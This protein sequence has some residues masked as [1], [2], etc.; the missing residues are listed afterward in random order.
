VSEPPSSSEAPSSWA[1]SPEL[2]ARVLARLGETGQP[3]ER[4]V[5]LFNVGNERYLTVL[6][7][8]Y[9]VPIAEHRRG[10]SFKLV[11]AYY[12]G[13][14]THFLLCLR[15]RAWRRGLAAAVVGLSPDDC[16]FD[17]PGRV[18]SAVAREI[19]LAPAGPEA[20]PDRGL[21]RVLG[22]LLDARRAAL[23]DGEARAWIDGT[24]RRVPCDAP[25]LRAAVVAWCAAELDGDGERAELAAAW[26]RGE[27]VS[28]AEARTLGIRQAVD[29]STGLRLLRGLTQLLQALGVPGLLLA[30]DELDRNLSLSPRRRRAVADNLRQVVDLCG[31]EAVPGLLC[32]YAVPPEFMRDVV[33]EYP[34]LQQRLEAPQALSRQ[35][36]QS[37]LI[38]LERLDL[39]P[40][41]VLVRVGKRLL[42]LFVL[43]TGARLDRRLQ[44]HNLR[45]L[46]DEILAGSFEIA[47]RR[48]FVKGAV[49]LLHRQ[50]LEEGPV[51]GGALRSMSG[52]GGRLVVLSGGDDPFDRF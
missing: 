5:E 6:D 21:E 2:A 26:M 41:E 12:G 50:A 1:P 15:E 46:A 39:P 3:P 10:S 42:A 43:A 38:D 23:G 40:H 9:L 14:K 51:D 22:A 29:K 49:D 4:G 20:P 25:S 33:S 24:L 17:D 45:A 18:W 11:Q 30:F 28:P 36:P 34:A 32:V 31:S 7:R 13:G 47:Q 44:E 8:E 52:Q 35:S 48:A 16:P 19:A 27:A 37:V